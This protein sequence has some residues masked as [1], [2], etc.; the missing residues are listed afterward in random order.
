LKNAYNP[1]PGFKLRSAY[2]LRNDPKTGTE[3]FHAGQDFRADA[4]TLIPAAASGKVV[5]SGFN[6]LFGNVVIVKNDAGGYSLY[7]HMQDGARAELG[8]RVWQGDALGQ[9]GSTGKSTGPH[10]HYAVIKPE[11]GE[12]I[13]MSKKPRNGGPIDVALGEKATFNPA[14]YDNYDPTPRYLDETRRVAEMMSG[15]RTG[16]TPATLSP[17]QGNSFSDRFERWGSSPVATAPSVTPHDPASFDQRSGTWGSAP[18][19]GVGVGKQPP[20]ATLDSLGPG[21]PFVSRPNRSLVAPG[22]SALL[23]PTPMDPGAPG[24]F[25]T[26]GRFVPRLSPPQPLYPTGPLVPAPSAR[27]QDRQGLLDD[28]SGNWSSSP[29]EDADRFRSPVLREL[30]KY[31]QL[32]ASGVAAAPSS[33]A[34]NLGTPTAPSGVGSGAGDVMGG[35]L[36]WIGNGLIPSAE[37]TPSKLLPQGG[38]APDFLGDSDGSI[39]D[40]S[41]AA[42]PLAKDNRRYLDRRVVGQG[43]AFDTGAPAVP[44][45]S[46]NAGLAPDYLNSF[47]DRFGNWPSSAGVTQP[48]QERPASAP[49]GLFTGEPMRN[50]ALPPSIFGLPDRSGVRGGF[51]DDRELDEP[52]GT[53]IP[54]LDE[55]IRY[56][57]REYPS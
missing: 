49:L 28:R 31:R 5:Y 18:A 50:K 37:A 34:S 57:N 35:V 38:T 36:K 9:V 26:G 23:D 45:I 42:P 40:A 15:A 25:S 20:V 46:S 3:K 53:G 44:F 16:K 1:G 24:P 43:S 21:I 32:A 6:E 2:G 51:S 47:E 4:G 48:A 52:L 8:R 33:A 27:M 30:Q 10:L 22:G 55:Y 56:L 19:G 29:A 13:E 7:A 17:G 11:A 14:E 39:S 41:E 54:M 12:I